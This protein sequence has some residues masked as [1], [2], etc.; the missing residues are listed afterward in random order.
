MP[1]MDPKWL[2]LFML[3]ATQDGS[4]DQL[5]P[6][7]GEPDPPDFNNTDFT[8]KYNVDKQ[9]QQT[10]YNNLGDKSGPPS[11]KLQAALNT[12]AKSATPRDAY[13]LLFG[14]VTQALFDSGSNYS[15]P[16]CPSDKTLA[17]V[18]QFINKEPLVVVEDIRKKGGKPRP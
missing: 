8:K 3:L 7:V 6:D 9:I 2:G 18:I 15:P 1:T 12:L 13:R 16:P 4:A 14:V 10:F 5:L 17:D 11:S